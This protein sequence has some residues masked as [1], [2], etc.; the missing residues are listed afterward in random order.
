V[1]KVSVELIFSHHRSHLT[2]SFFHDSERV[3]HPSEHESIEVIHVLALAS[4]ISIEALRIHAF[5]AIGLGW[6]WWDPVITIW[7]LLLLLLILLI[8]LHVAIFKTKEP[9]TTVKL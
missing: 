1:S 5:K 2:L 8:V 3:H 9:F 4:L 7:L 6:R